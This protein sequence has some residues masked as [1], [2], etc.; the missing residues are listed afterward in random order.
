MSSAQ[1]ATFVGSQRWDANPGIDVMI[2]DAAFH[3]TDR[4]A[5]HVARTIISNPWRAI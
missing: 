3:L 1:T 5:N 2:N 4:Q